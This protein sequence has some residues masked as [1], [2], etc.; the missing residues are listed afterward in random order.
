MLLDVQV[1][2]GVAPFCKETR[3]VNLGKYITLGYDAKHYSQHQKYATSAHINSEWLLPMESHPILQQL[4]VTCTM[5]PLSAVLLL[6]SS[7]LAS[8]Q[9]RATSTAATAPWPVQ[10]TTG[11]SLTNAT[12]ESIPYNGTNTYTSTNITGNNPYNG[13]NTTMAAPYLPAGGDQQTNPSYTAVSNF[14]F[15]SLVSA[16]FVRLEFLCL[17]RHL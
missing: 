9:P 7:V 8:P 1:T 16:F 6:A 2:I 14:D 4:K 5:L 15:Q 13:T 12:I 3:Q 10:N 17:Y 11:I